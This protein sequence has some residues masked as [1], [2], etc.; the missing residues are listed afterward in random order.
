MMEEVERLSIERGCP[1]LNLQ[2]R[3]SNA[4]VI[5]FYNQLGYQVY[6]VVSMGKRLIPD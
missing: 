6:E 4:A 2:I 1:K 3:S 5:S